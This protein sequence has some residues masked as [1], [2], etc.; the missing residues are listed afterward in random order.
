MKEI[1][2]GFY[3]G[4]RSLFQG[5]DLRIVDTIFGEGESPLKESRNIELLG[6]MFR[7]K[8]PLW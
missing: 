6:S 1:K 4:E 8:Y 2:Q 7:G 5:K 3:E